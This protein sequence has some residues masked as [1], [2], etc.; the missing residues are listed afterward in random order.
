VTQLSPFVVTG[1]QPGAT[2]S[3]SL[4]SNNL[5]ST[6][7]PHIAEG[8]AEKELPNPHADNDVE[9]EDLQDIP[10]ATDTLP[11]LPEP[12]PV[13]T[14]F[15]VE[16]ILK[17]ASAGEGA[18]SATA[19]VDKRASRVMRLAEENEKLDAELRALSERIAKAEKRTT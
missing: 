13:D 7:R 18:T 2:H 9:D 1:R 17:A 3:T 11:V 12:S 6:G 14:S 5:N 10:R 8:E 15:S 16:S 19:N 4:Q